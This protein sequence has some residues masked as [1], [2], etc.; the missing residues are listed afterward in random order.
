MRGKM[1]ACLGMMQLTLRQ[2]IFSRK[3]IVL[4]V[5][6]LLPTLLVVYALR[7]PDVS[8]PFVFL[9]DFTYLLY[10]QIVLVLIT[11]VNS[12][13]LIRD[14][15]S[16][17]TISFL[18]TRSISRGNVALSRYVAHMP[19]NFVLVALPV[20]FCYL[21]MGVQKGG[22]FNNLDILAGYLLMIL[23]GVVVYGAFFYMLGILVK[24]PLM[25]GLL[26]AFL[27]EVLLTNMQ[28]RIPYATIMFYIRSLGFSI[29]DTGN[30]QMELGTTSAKYSVLALVAVTACILYIAR[31]RFMSMDLI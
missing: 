10:I 27:W 19:V 23:L 22:L 29:I 16:N 17:K 9:S 2:M 18:V 30:L 3:F 8:E 24:H 20:S 4:L 11:L 7:R 28:G 1:G 12:T 6:T 13:S 15:I 5:L 31:R 26:F 21:Y 25:I 14:E